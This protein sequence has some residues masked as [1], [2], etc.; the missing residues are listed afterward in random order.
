MILL[1]GLLLLG[2]IVV[3]VVSR[4][5]V[6]RLVFLGMVTQGEKA[7]AV[8]TRISPGYC[9]IMARLEIRSIP[10]IVLQTGFQPKT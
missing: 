2:S 9:E 4:R 3:V 8:P 10:T 6:V 7:W 1:R 5:R